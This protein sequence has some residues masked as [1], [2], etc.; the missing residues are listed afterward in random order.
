MEILA[1]TTALIYQPLEEQPKVAGQRSSAL[2]EIAVFLGILLLANFLWFG[3][4]RFWG[5]EPHPFW[6]IVLLIAVQYGTSEGLIAAI[7]ASAALL[8]G[9]M[10]E[11][12]LDQNGYDYLFM[13][14]KLP[15]LWIVTAFVLGELRQRH[16][17]EREYL[18]TE[19]NASR[20]R[21]ELIGRSYDKVKDLKEKL[22]LRIASQLR[23]NVDTY[24]AA[25]AIEKN[26]PSD[27]L[28]GVQELIQSVMSAEKFSVFTLTN[29]GLSTTI[30]HGWNEG[31]KL[32]KHFSTHD[33]LYQEVVGK[34][35]VL[36]VANEDHQRILGGQGV[37]A[38]PLVDKE[39]GE[40]NG[41]LK[42]ERLG[43]LELNLST[44]ESFRAICEWVGM[45][46]VNARKYQDAKAGSMINP[47]HNLMSYGYFRQYTDYISALGKRVGFAVQMVVIQ[48]TNAE[49]LSADHRV[50]TARVVSDAVKDA[51]RTVDLAFDYQK[52]G[53]E[54]SIV[55]PATTREGAKI[56]LDKLESSIQK[57]LPKSIN[58]DF[59]L[60]I[61]TIHETKS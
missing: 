32:A 59:A 45:A 22:E 9:N 12:R 26:N 60:T 48:L 13:I 43:F 5:M 10:P 40:I 33:S 36:C 50:K 4:D 56:V 49:K 46:L 24:R 30:T 6:A 47:D 42:I 8:L 54:Y 7:L 19:L 61:H 23:A 55:L 31:D 25:R 18:R 58:A 3:G 39:T 28:N 1:M 27:V 14:L 21:E 37:L 20:E 16:I 41:M 29:E 17:R 51:L 2:L 35:N 15:L 34:Q 57:K 38:G 11:Q 53:Q 52:G 44:V